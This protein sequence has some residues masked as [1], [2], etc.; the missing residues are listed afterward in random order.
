MPGIAEVVTGAPISATVATLT[1]TKMDIILEGR[2]LDGRIATKTLVTGVTVDPASPLP[3]EIAA[4]DIP[5]Q[6]LGGV[7]QMKLLMKYTEGGVEKTAQAG[8]LRMH[9]TFDSTFTRAWASSDNM[10]ALDIAATTLQAGGAVIPV[11][12]MNKVTTYSNDPATD[13]A[14]G[15]K[16]LSIGET[17]DGRF[18]NSAGAWVS[19]SSAQAGL[20][21]TG[22]G[23]FEWDGPFYKKVRAST[24]FPVPVHD[25]L[26]NPIDVKFCFNIRT[27]FRDDGTEAYL[28]GNQNS[29]FARTLASVYTFNQTNT[30]FLNQLTDANGCAA[31]RI[32]EN[33]RCFTTFL[34]SSL[35]GEGATAF[36]VI[37]RG[38]SKIYATALCVAP[39]SWN[40]SITSVTSTVTTTCCHELQNAS[41]VP[42][43][44]VPADGSRDRVGLADV[45][46]QS[47]HQWREQAKHRGD[48][49]RVPTRLRSKR[50]TVH[51]E[52]CQRR[53]LLGQHRPT[54]A[55]GR[56]HHNTANA[57]KT[58]QTAQP[59]CEDEVWCWVTK[60]PTV[61]NK[62]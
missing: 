60:V 39:A 17:E 40:A 45:P 59:G 31:V 14:L 16:L 34:D 8:P 48:R 6:S 29:P 61:D 35:I 2:G 30:P 38:Q 27:G 25:L 52:P 21:Y 7:V 36:K 19:L 49:R 15:R 51:K 22:G 5:V 26:M 24:P 3:V 53:S 9:A 54:A 11:E 12:V 62:S 10:L 55:A 42:Q 46:D 32:T 44:Q 13:V 41:E 50:H 57:S 33:F 28:R 43:S 20:K 4:A 23:W 1:A 47:A 37:E 18:L 58:T 56:P